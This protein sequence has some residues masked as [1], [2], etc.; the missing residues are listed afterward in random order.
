VK[1]AKRIAIIGANGQLGSRL[2]ERLGDEVIGITRRDM[3]LESDAEI[4]ACLDKHQPEM[5]INAAAYTNVEKA[6]SEAALA[7]R[8]N[9]AAPEAMAYWARAHGAAL[10]HFSTDYV[11]DGTLDMPYSEVDATNPLNAYGQSKSEGEKAVLKMYPHALI[12]RTSWLY[13]AR[14]KNFFTT[15]AAKLRA[16]NMLQIVEDQKGVPCYAPDI[17]QATA[18]L[19]ALPN[20]PHGIVHCVSQGFTSWYYFAIAIRDAMMDTLA[21][22]LAVIEPVS[23]SQ[24]ETK[25]TRPKDSRLSPALLTSLTGITLPVWQEGVL[26]AVQEHYAH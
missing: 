21:E 25:A 12:L 5:I 11:F 7:H 18:Q 26:R 2:C 15:I 14:G 16:S 20:L 19:L 13:D 24:Y 6:E 8:I 9:A 4:L 17:A 10:I 1:A 22:P 3:A 23:S